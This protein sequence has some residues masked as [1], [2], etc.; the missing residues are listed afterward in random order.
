MPPTMSC[1]PNIYQD[2]VCSD[3]VDVNYRRP[4]TDNCP[5]MKSVTYTSGGATIFGP[6]TDSFYH[7]KN[8]RSII[9]A[10]ATDSSGNTASCDINVEINNGRFEIKLGFYFFKVL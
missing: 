2:V 7:M 3:G 4:A 10:I 9:T 8:G 6:T 1:S 5:H